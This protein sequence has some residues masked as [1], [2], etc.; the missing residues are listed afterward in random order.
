MQSDEDDYRISDDDEEESEIEPS[1]G[2]SSRAVDTAAP[3]DKLTVPR[4]SVRASAASQRYSL[5][6][7]RYKEER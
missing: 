4:G 2:D 7:L 6:H 5:L 3:G 1:G